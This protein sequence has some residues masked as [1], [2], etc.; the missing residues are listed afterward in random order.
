MRAGQ[1]DCRITIERPG[2]VTG[3]YGPQP[4]GWVPVAA[5]VPAQVLDTLP[6]KGEAV[7]E[8]L[9]QATRPARLRM[10]YMRGITSDMRVILHGETDQVFQIVGG[11]AELGRRQWLE[12]T[13]EQYSTQGGGNG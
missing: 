2:T 5:R 6:S 13:I 1:M 11:P 9:A 4:G 3:A 7:K 10:R 8:G 12:M